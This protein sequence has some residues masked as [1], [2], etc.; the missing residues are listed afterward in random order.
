[1]QWFITGALDRVDIVW[2]QQVAEFF[3][4]PTPVGLHPPHSLRRSPRFA[5]PAG[6]VK[7]EGQKFSFDDLDFPPEMDSSTLEFVRRKTTHARKM[8]GFCLGRG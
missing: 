7:H 6:F 1:M 2:S 4:M 3:S 8:S 5:S